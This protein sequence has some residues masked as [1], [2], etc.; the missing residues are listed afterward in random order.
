MNNAMSTEVFS[1]PISNPASGASP[2]NLAKEKLLKGLADL[3]RQRKSI[4]DV[5]SYMEAMERRTGYNLEDAPPIRKD[6]FRGA[7]AV[8]ALESYLR[9]RRGFRIPLSRIVKDL[10]EGGVDPGQPRGKKNDPAGLVAHTLKIAVP[11]RRDVF[12][13]E[14]SAVNEKTGAHVIPKGIRD[15]DI[16]VWLADTADQPRRRKRP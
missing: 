7:R 13:Y 11:N 9:T 3:D 5:L 2:I 6:E 12:G 4:M 14:P 16:L 10:V 8:Q 1:V 15:E